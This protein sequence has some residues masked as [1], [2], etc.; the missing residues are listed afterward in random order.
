MLICVYANIFDFPLGVLHIFFC[1]LA[2][3]LLRQ[4]I[5]VERKLSFK[6]C[7]KK[8]CYKWSESVATLYKASK[9]EP[10]LPNYIAKNCHMSQGVRVSKFP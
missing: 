2:R 7:V 10:Y 8:S 5:C 3:N 6:T 1:S 4:H 9:R